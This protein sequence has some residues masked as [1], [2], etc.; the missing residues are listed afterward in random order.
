[1][2]A[3][4]SW[5][6]RAGLTALLAAST[7]CSLIYDADVF[8]YIDAAP[9]PDTP[10]PD[11]Y[12][13]DAYVPDAYVPDADPNALRITRLDPAEVPE[14]AGCIPLDTGCRADSRPVP[15]VIHGANITQDAQVLVTGPGFPEEGMVLDLTVDHTGTVAAFALSLPVLP[16]LGAGDTPSLTLT[17]RQAVGEAQ[18][19][20]AVRSLDEFVASV[21]APGGTFNTAMLRDLYSRIDIDAPVRFTGTSRVRL[22]AV[23]ELVVQAALRADGNNASGGAAGVAGPGGCNGGAGQAA[24]SC[25]GGGQAGSG[26]GGGGGGGHAEQG[27]SGS[28]EGAGTGGTPTGEV[29]LTPLA[30]V[31]SNAARGH[32]GGG[33]GVS[34]LAG[35]AGGGGGG[36]GGSLELTSQGLLRLTTDASLSVK[37][38]NGGDGGGCLGSTGG[39]GGGSG[40]AILARAA[41]AFT[42]EGDTPRV[43]VSPGGGGSGTGGGGGDGGTGALGRVRIDLPDPPDGDPIPDAFSDVTHLYRG[44]TWSPTAPII[45]T[46][47]DPLALALSGEPQAT[48]FTDV[49]G[50]Q[51][52][53]LI[54]SA[55]GKL[56]V[57]IMA[58]SPGQNQI[59]AR[60]TAGNDSNQ[61]DAF[62]CIDIAYIPSR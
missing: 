35:G 24:G 51:R 25:A 26:E 6:T 7:S 50:D 29:F 27:L 11:A 58:L 14:G 15:I 9:P 54:F 42:D 16:D 56:A 8:N 3:I 2:S 4:K 61:P 39:G 23:S 36:G 19:T 5:Y 47:N 48:V 38:G 60:V 28:G 40:G 13:P 49:E 31:A 30:P 46:E 62:H 18:A 32:G 41:M 33:G 45:V 43:D 37:G 10:P 1:M 59:C 44:P 52:R 12:V 21:A 22:I 57:E 20:L 53:D 34:C 55:D 17:L